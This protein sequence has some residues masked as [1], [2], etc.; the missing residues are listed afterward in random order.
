MFI[1]ISGLVVGKTNTT[2]KKTHRPAETKPNYTRKKK[3]LDNCV[4]L[5]SNCGFLS[6]GST[7]SLA[8]LIPPENLLQ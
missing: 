1:D 4:Y 8:L 2:R 6:Y 7:V 3:L 5:L